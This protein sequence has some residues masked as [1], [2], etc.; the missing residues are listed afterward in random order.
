MWDTEAHVHRLH[1]DL[2]RLIIFLFG[3]ESSLMIKEGKKERN[4]QTNKK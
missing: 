2:K 4:K 1:S 3:K